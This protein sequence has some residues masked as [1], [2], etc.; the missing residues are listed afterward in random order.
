MPS[1]QASG[2]FGRLGRWIATSIL[3]A[4]VATSAV[5]AITVR[6]T[7]STNSTWSTGTGPYLLSGAVTVAPGV[8]LTVE[9]GVVIKG[10]GT[11]AVLLV[12]GTLLV[13]GTA[14]SRVMFT[15]ALDDFGGDSN[16][17][18]AASLPARGNWNGILF[19]PGSSGNV[20]N[21]ATIRYGGFTD[22]GRQSRLVKVTARPRAC[23]SAAL[24]ATVP[25]FLQ[26]F[27]CAESGDW[28]RLELALSFG[29]AYL[30]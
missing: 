27:V 21:Y 6:G 26:L 29:H 7:I 16:G 17:D 1:L 12:D 25:T 14:G 9:P 2:P 23:R 5:A 20:I 15:S 28:R 30:L 4:V 13:N 22:M 3:A 19:R 24:S 18:V 11:G 8:T 10:N